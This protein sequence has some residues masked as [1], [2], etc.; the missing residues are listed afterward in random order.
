MKKI[1][2][3]FAVLTTLAV[4]VGCNS[5]NSSDVQPIQ[6]QKDTTQIKS[7]Q[8]AT[9][10]YKFMVKQ[11]FSYM[12]KNKDNYISLEEYKAA[13]PAAPTVNPDPAQPSVADKARTIEDLVPSKD[14]PAPAPS[15][16]PVD[17]APTPTATPKPVI[18]LTPEQLFK[19]IDKNKDGK[20]SLTESQNSKYF[21][22]MSI[23][24]MRKYIAQY[25]FKGAFKYSLGRYTGTIT[26]EQFMNLS[27]GASIPTEYAQILNNSFYVADRNFDG[28]LN[29]SEAED[30]LYSMMR[31]TYNPVNPPVQ[32][33]A[34]PDPVVSSS[35]DPYA[36]DPSA[37]P[38]VEPTASV[39]V[40]PNI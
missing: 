8:G 34:Y 21:I 27:G 19:K 6:S 30:M 10:A 26:K 13:H 2:S 17:P 22:G 20:L 32:P 31:A 36:P 14:D 7:V 38:S 39:P 33:S 11:G 35:P 37:V 29:F 4:L 9:Y 24:D 25:Y 23:S 12:D 16:A 18:P 15:V 1:G 40:T 28:K 5:N 3:F